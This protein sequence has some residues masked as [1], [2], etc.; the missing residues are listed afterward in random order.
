MLNNGLRLLKMAEAIGKERII[1]KNRLMKMLK[2][3]KEI[4]I[5]LEKKCQ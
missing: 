5:R 2:K 1:I 4:V 3:E